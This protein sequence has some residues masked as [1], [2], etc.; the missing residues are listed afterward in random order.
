MVNMAAVHLHVVKRTDAV[1]NRERNTTNHGYSNEEAH[2]SEK[3]TFPPALSQMPPV[4]VPEASA[5]YKQREYGESRR[6]D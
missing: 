5:I 3:Q 6:Y 4:D 2:R 1:M